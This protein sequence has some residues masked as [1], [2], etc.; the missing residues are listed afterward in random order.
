MQGR[1]ITCNK[2]YK[3]VGMFEFEELCDRPVGNADY[4]AISQNCTTILLKNIPNF[5]VNNR[6][7][8]RRFIN[9]V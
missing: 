8:M 3:G 2:Y 7:V 6:N 9:L 4:I 1:K 5:S